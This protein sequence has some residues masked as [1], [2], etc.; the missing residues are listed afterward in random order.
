MSSVA[1]VA[2]QSRTFPELKARAESGDAKSQVEVGVAYASGSGVPVDDAEAVR[3]FRKAAEQRNAAGEYSLGEMYATGRGVGKDYSQAARWIQKAA[4]QGDVRALTNL[5]AMYL[6]GLGV[7]QD[8]KK[9][10][11]LIR[12]AAEQ[13]FAAAEFGLGRMY[14]RGQGIPRNLSEAVKWYTKGADQGDPDSMN[15]LSWLLATGTNHGDRNPRE[16]V[17]LALRATRATQ[18]RVPQYFDTLA[19]AFYANGQYGE[20]LGAE[21]KALLLQPDNKGYQQ[22][23]SNYQEIVKVSS[24]SKQQSGQARI[25]SVAPMPVFTPDPEPSPEHWY[26]V[27]TVSTS[28]GRDGRVQEPRVIRSVSSDIDRKALEAIQKWIFRPAQK[29]GVPVEIKLTV[30]VAFHP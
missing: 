24:P 30:E 5:G 11:R 10:F 7:T 14:S 18:E 4:D 19:N 8:E 17:D 29:D 16:A 15:N 21:Q 2:A 26:G 9:A 28:I 12:L 1:L 27:V 20:A 23:S 22:L 3:W 13:G 25:G 6:L